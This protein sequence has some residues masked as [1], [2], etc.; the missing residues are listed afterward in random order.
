[1][2]TISPSRSSSTSLRARRRR[3]EISD[4][5]GGLL[6]SAGGIVRVLPRLGAAPF[7]VVNADTFWIDER[8]A[9]PRPAWRLPGM[10]ARMDIL[11]MLADLSNRRPDTRVAPTSLVGAGRDG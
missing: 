7:Y 11:L 5:R 8:R 6:D 3:I 2:C 4:E 10:P 9:Q 1:M